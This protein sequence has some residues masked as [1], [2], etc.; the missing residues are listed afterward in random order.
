ME[1][2]VNPLVLSISTD[3]EESGSVISKSAIVDCDVREHGFSG[4][5]TTTALSGAQ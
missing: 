1:D 5:H 4:L 3:L 2:V